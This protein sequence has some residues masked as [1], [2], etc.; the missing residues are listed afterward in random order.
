LGK[1]LTQ[2]AIVDI[3]LPDKDGIELTRQIKTAQRMGKVPYQSVDLTLRDT[4][5][6]VLA[7]FAAGQTLLHERY[8]FENLL[9]RCGLLMGAIL[10]LT[11]QSLA[12]Y[13]NKRNKVQK[14]LKQRLIQ[15]CCYQCS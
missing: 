10:G 9:E 11:R 1:Q 4:K 13:C 14:P 3:G 15:N 8:G 2:I 6:A 12:L 5:E 7:A